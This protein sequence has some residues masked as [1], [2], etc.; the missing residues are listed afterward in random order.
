MGFLDRKAQEFGA[1]KQQQAMQQAGMGGMGG[2]DPMEAMRQA[3]MDPNAAVVGAM[4][5]PGDVQEQIATRDRIQ[6]LNQSG[7]AGA[8]TV[9]GVRALGTT[10]GGVG[11]DTEVDLKVT[12][13]P[14]APQ[15]ITVK[16]SMIGDSDW[17]QVGKAVTL[18]IDPADPSQAL[19]VGTA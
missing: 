9:I 5:N 15:M 2:Y 4:A 10:A 13:G 3:G 17:Y 18:K 7:V 6:R 8:A 11:T 1:A 19:L 12:E 16:Q 14:G